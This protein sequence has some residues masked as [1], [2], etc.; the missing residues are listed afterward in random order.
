VIRIAAAHTL[1][2]AE[3]FGL[4]VLVDLSRVLVAG[5]EVDAALTLSVVDDGPTPAPLAQ[6]IANQWWIEAAGEGEVQVRRSALGRL[7]ELCSAAAEQRSAA[8]DRFGRVPPGEN[9]LVGSGVE[10]T[11]VVSRAAAR[12]ATVASEAAARRPFRMLQPWPGG[13]RW[14]VALSHDLDAVDWWPAFT[15]LRLVELARK[16]EIGRALRVVGAAIRAAPGKPTEAGVRELL[17]T[18]ADAGVPATWFVLCGTPTFATMRAGDLTYDPGGSL[19]TRI[20][21]RIAGAGHE[22]GL[23]GSFE[24]ADDGSR[25][26][27][28]RGRLASLAGRAVAGVRQHYL[29]MR[30]A[31]TPGQMAAAGFT[32]DSTFGFA[33]RNGFRLGVA[34]VVPAWSVEK[35]APA[36]IELAPFAWMDRA[37]SKYR[38]VE[39]PGAWV[40]DGLRLATEC[41][42][43]NGLWVGV[44]HPNLTPALG[45]PGAP[46]AY[47]RLL[48]ALAAEDPHFGTLGEIVAWRSSRRAVRARAI[49]PDGSVAA[50]ASPSPGAELRLEGRDGRPLEL[51]RTVDG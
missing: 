49:A 16:K 7:A 18:E 35:G 44:W 41:R 46:D 40:A 43:V 1:T 19:A 42:A 33:D 8:K 23:H 47:R 25:F 9:E 14:A 13:K 24:T 17:G 31:T 48:R 5:P 30:P 50:T 26:R 10:G 20:L 3:R 34:D 2:P 6:A 37:L 36:G 29:R 22:I 12:L 27:D 15:G 39:E 32:Y 21:E 11:A 51:V 45:Y 4:E 28:Q 38:G